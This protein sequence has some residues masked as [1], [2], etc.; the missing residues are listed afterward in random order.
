VAISHRARV[1]A[2]WASALLALGLITAPFRADA[3][4]FDTGNATVQIVIPTVIPTIYEAVSP[5]AADAT[6]VL[7]ITTLLTN[8][9]FDAIAPYH[10]TAVGVYAPPSR[11]PPHERT[12]ANRNV[13]ILHASFHV[14]ESLLPNYTELWRGM[15]IDVGL[16]PDDGQVNA[17]SAVGLGNRAGKAVVAARENDGMNQLGDEGDQLYHRRPYADYTGYAP[18][19]TAYDLIDPSRWQPDILT[20]GTGLFSVQQFVTPQMSITTPYTY[21]SPDAFMAPAPV[22]SDPAN[23]PAYMSQA[24]E[25]LGA[26]A[27]LTDYQKMAAEFFD[28]KLRSLGFSAF[29]LLEAYELSLEEFVHVDLLL[30]LAAFDTAIAIWNNKVM[31]DAVRPFS[32]IRYLYGDDPV[33]AWGGPGEGT[34]YD[35]PGM[36]WRSY[37]QTADHP[38]Y[39]SGSAALCAAHA[40][41]ARRYFDTDNFGWSVAA[42]Q[43]SSRIEPGVTPAQDIVLGPWLTWTAF[44]EECALTRF[45]A[46]V[47]FMPSLAGGQ[48]IGHPIG[49]LAHEFVQAHIAGTINSMQRV[50]GGR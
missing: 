32:A 21:G 43:G 17:S 39:P 37:L 22:A 12:D 47:H 30:N 44:E 5:S 25:V 29:Y 8:A 49:N 23:Y 4:D 38:E 41:A 27:A 45:W 3:F 2:G 31:Y 1:R 19:N 50:P 16:D 42:P 18:V 34:V 36:Q 35:M 26:S 9:W 14:L 10:P 11:R 7:R 6:L 15:L 46:G 40:Q 28:D 33:S 20:T 24:A 13:A 48:G